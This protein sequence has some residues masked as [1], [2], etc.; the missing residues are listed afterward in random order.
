M[1]SRPD[2][3]ERMMRVAVHG[4]DWIERQARRNPQL[5]RDH[6]L[7][8][9]SEQAPG[10]DGGHSTI[11]REIGRRL[12]HAIELMNTGRREEERFTL[13]SLG[14]H[15][16]H[17]DWRT[18]E[19]LIAGAGDQS[20]AE[21]ATLAERLGLSAPWLIEGKGAPF[22]VDLYCR[23]LDS[24]ELYDDMTA[25]KPRQVV[26]VRQDYPDS[27]CHHVLIAVQFDEVR[28]TVH[29]GMWPVWAKL[30]SGG[31]HD[32][33]ALY[34]LIKRLDAATP[35]LGFLANGAHADEETF[36]GLS[37][38]EVYPGS[39][40]NEFRND[41]WPQFLSSLCMRGLDL[42]LPREKSL[43]ETIDMLS[44][45]VSEEGVRRHATGISARQLH[46]AESNAA[47][48]R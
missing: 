27:E 1:L 31:R 4:W 14:R 9:W 20:D 33:I 36:D 37:M 22:E 42:D 12:G 43:A 25:A 39:L 15:L 32:L 18:L 23:R 45:L 19:K 40:Y 5:A 26:F 38:G 16:G 34:C 7:I 48:R 6:H 2:D 3:K 41:E 11:A 29:A 13:Q 28:W 17:A 35:E 44:F 21:L 8:G 46:W 24:I 10:A 47:G 30:G